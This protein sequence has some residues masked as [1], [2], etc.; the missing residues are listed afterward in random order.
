MSATF[1]RVWEG[2]PW[3]VTGGV[4][5]AD[6]ITDLEYGD[7]EKVGEW[8]RKNI[9]PAADVWPVSSYGL[10]HSMEK[11]LKLSVSNNQFKDAMLLAG[12]DPVDAEEVNWHWRIALTR[13]DVVNPSP[14]FRW[15]SRRWPEGDCS[16]DGI[17][18]ADICRDRTFPVLADYGVIAGYLK[19][20][21]ACTEFCETFDRMWDEY[22][23]DRGIPAVW[24]PTRDER[25]RAWTGMT[26]SEY[27]KHQAEL[28]QFRA[29]RA[30]A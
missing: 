5:D 4:E 15:V 21:G 9:R 14:F 29:E 22:A 10:K 12:Y 13:Y 6:L 7:L 2:R 8:I 19:K 20:K 11:D 28:E 17:W 16:T 25:W 18:A 24:L 27:R 23:R 26:E 1:S 3:T 30:R